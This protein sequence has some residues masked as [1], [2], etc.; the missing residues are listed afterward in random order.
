MVA[1]VRLLGVAGQGFSASEA[2]GKSLAMNFGGGW[3]G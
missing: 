3:R 1:I 2:R